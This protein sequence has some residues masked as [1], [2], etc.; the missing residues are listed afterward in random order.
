VHYTTTNGGSF[1]YTFTGTGIDYLSERYSDQ[2]LV[3]IYLDGVLKATVDTANGV[4][5]TQQVIYS[6]RGLP[7]GQ[8]TLR[9]VKRSGTYMLVDRF[10][11]VAQ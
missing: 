7:Q 9:G 5:L 3:D 1:T 11:V 10:D 4:R 6:V 2:G 8:H